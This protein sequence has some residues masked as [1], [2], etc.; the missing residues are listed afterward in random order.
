MKTKMVSIFVAT[1]LVGGSLEKISA[2]VESCEDWLEA[3]SLEPAPYDETFNLLPT[4]T[5]NTLLSY[6]IRS[7]GDLLKESEDSLR[8]MHGVG[9]TTLMDIQRFL[10]QLGFSLAKHTI[11]HSPPTVNDH[12]YMLPISSRI[13]RV[14]VRNG[15]K[16]IADLLKLTSTELA[17]LDGIGERSIDEITLALSQYNLSLKP[18]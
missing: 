17:Q 12:V 11:E 1:V 5:R 3:T 4:R 9:P 14:L 18:D 8:R 7:L 10:S 16:K 13:K 6:H 15:I 2:A